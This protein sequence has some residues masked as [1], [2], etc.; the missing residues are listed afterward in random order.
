MQ[1]QQWYTEQTSDLSSL[2]V[3]LH[4]SNQRYGSAIGRLQLAAEAAREIVALQNEHERAPATAL[5]NM[6][7]INPRSAQILRALDVLGILGAKPVA[8]VID[9]GNC[10]S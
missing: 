1:S 2:S 9:T 10:R 8:Y 7:K 4:P 5:A 6:R 3:L